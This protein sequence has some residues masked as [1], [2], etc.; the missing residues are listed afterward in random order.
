MDSLDAIGARL[1]TADDLRAL[2]TGEWWLEV[3]EYG[4]E[5]P[6]VHFVE[7]DLAVE[8]LAP[9]DGPWALVVH[10]DLHATGDLD[11]ST[12]DYKVSLLVVRGSVRTR[13]LRFT[14]GANCIVS[15]DLDASGYVLGRYGDESAQL[16]V[17]GTLRAR[18]LLLDH[19]TGCDAGAIE[20]IV[21]SSAG[22]R[23]PL[24]LD[25]SAESHEDLLV[26]EA[27]AGG[28]IG[29]AEAWEVATRG[30][31]LFLPGV[32]ER[33]RAARPWPFRREG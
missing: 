21:C 1:L 23:L 10:G 20:A 13:N 11:F 5:P 2:F 27:L 8:S 7:G 25:Y 32:E 33:L 16:V 26:P 18:A 12:S 14:N 30:R 17:G 31:E 22:W 15:H 4:D 9:G 29:I 6:A 28:T 24:D 3:L 19:V